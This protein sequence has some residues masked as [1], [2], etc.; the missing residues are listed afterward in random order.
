[1]LINYYLIK[2]EYIILDNN[3]LLEHFYIYYIDEYSIR[4]IFNKKYFIENNIFINNNIKIKLFS[5]DKL[6]NEIINFDNNLEY[7]DIKTN[8]LLIEYY[9]NIIPKF[10]PP[11]NYNLIKNN[12][13][14]LNNYKLY[15]FNIVIYYIDKNEANILIR[16][17]DSEF[18]WNDEL[19]IIIES[20]D[21]KKKI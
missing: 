9:T 3:Y 7:I 8:N 18:G 12:Y 21:K 10:I 16:R 2:N 14:I 17:L 4:I 5:I 20:I 11:R 15:D 19:N 6:N 1:M 13:Y